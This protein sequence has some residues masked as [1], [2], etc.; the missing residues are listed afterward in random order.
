MKIKVVLSGYGTV[1]KEF[2]KLLHE[3]CSYIYE[4]YMY[5]VSCKWRIRQK[6]LQYIIK[7]DYLFITY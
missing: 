4:T 7:M 3:K 1:G 2:I 6:C 5:R